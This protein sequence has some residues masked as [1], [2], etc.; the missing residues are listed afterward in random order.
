M[1]DGVIGHASLAL[2]YTLPQGRPVW[3]VSSLGDE[4]FIVR[5]RASNIEVYH[6]S[7]LHRRLEVPQL[8]AA[9]DLAACHVHSCLY[10]TDVGNAQPWRRY[11][12]HRSVPRL[13]HF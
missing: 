8:T 6:Y 9:R 10:V 5:E 3:G 2:L 13:I 7:T 11:A 4:L 1:C 12:I